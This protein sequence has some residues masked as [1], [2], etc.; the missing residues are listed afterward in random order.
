MDRKATADRLTPTINLNG[1]SGEALAR[2]YS[3]VAA[4]AMRLVEALGRAAPH[5]RDWQTRPDVD[6][7]QARDQWREL[8]TTAGII[9]N[10]YATLT[11][12]A[13]EQERLR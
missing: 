6:F 12:R 13:L 9:E 11:E 7:A 1:T 10:V 2:Q 8:V 3:E 4:A 5:G